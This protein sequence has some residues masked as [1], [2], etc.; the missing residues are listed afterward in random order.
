MQINRLL[1][2]VYVLLEK[3]QVTAKQLSEQFGVSQR[4]I[5][6]DIDILSVAGIPV[7][8]EKGKGGGISLLP[9]FVLD[10]SLLNEQEQNEILSALQALSGIMPSAPDQVLKKMSGIFKRAASDWLQVDFTD[11]NSRRRGSFNYFKTAILERRI[12]EFEYY[13]ANG[14]KTFR[15]IEPIQLCFMSKAW[16]VKGFCLQRQDIRSF[17]LNR[18]RNI[19]LTGKHFSARSLPLTILEPEAAQKNRNISLK[20]KIEPEMIHRVFDEFGDEEIEK[21]PDGSFIVRATWPEDNWVYGF[22]LSFGEYIEV[23]EPKR[24]QKIL[25]SKADKI[26]KKYL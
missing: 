12:T 4:T 5:F 22:L 14:E 17:K 21:Q 18:I 19:K 15:R 2:I 24:I 11:W 8:A 9:E 1:E 3:K 20:L 6:R 10:K 26:L 13:A 16:Y 25:K 7:Y 23:L